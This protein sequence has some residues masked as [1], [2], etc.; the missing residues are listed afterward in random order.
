MVGELWI[1]SLI[2]NSEYSEGVLRVVIQVGSMRIT[3]RL[4]RVA[5]F[6]HECK[7]TASAIDDVLVQH[8]TRVYMVD[9]NAF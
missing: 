4:R 2:S 1:E 8:Q 5:S 9:F 7:A 3:V 6:V